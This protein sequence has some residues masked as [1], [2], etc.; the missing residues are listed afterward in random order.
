[1]LAA[2]TVLAVDRYRPSARMRRYLAARDQHCRF[3]GCRAPLARCDLD[4]T[5]DAALGGAT[6]TDNL[7]HLCRGHHTLKHHGGWRV[8][9]NDDGALEWRSP[10]GRGYRERPPGRVVFAGAPG[11]DSAPQPA[12]LPF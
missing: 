5:V 6:A 3:P 2:G 9:Q 1:V 12:A 8:R 10:T 11:H 7:A 4:H